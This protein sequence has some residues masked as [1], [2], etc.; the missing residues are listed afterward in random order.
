L[1]WQ[2]AQS[3]IRLLIEGDRPGRSRNPRAA[4]ACYA[5]QVEKVNPVQHFDGLAALPASL[6]AGA[7]RHALACLGIYLLDWPGSPM[8]ANS[9]VAEGVD[10]R[11]SFALRFLPMFV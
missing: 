10:F 9:S 6:Q 2:V 7:D 8:P 3:F 1:F 11:L 4:A 5:D